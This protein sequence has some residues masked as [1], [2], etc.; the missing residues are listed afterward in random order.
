MAV[1]GARVSPGTTRPARKLMFSAVHVY[2][3]CA[4]AMYLQI[5]SGLRPVFRG[6]GFVEIFTRA[7]AR[8]G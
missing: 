8:N 6:L 2:S 1:R 7:R 5:R 3:V 4:Y